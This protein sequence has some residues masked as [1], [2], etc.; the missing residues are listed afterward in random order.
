MKTPLP[1]LRTTLV[2]ST[3]AAT[4]AAGAL[5]AAH[6]FADPEE[7]TTPT[8]TRGG[9][10]AG[11]V[12]ANQPLTGTALPDGAAS[13]SKF[14]F[15][16]NGTDD[17]L[18]LAVATIAL[19]KGAEPSNGWPVVV[20]AAAPTGID[21]RCAA[22]AT[23]VKTAGDKTSEALLAKGFAVLTPDYGGI[24][25]PTA[26]Q[27]SDNAVTARHLVDA[28]EAGRV[29]AGLSPR[30]A[31]AGE[32]LGSGAAIELARK[33]TRWESG[34]LDF[35]GTAATSLPAGFADLVAGLGKSSPEVSA[36]VVADVV[37]ALASLDQEALEPVLSSKGAE[38]V[39]KAATGCADDL[40]RAVRGVSLSELVTKPL[41]GKLA[42]SVRKSLELPQRG[43]NRPV[44]L[45]QTLTDETTVVPEAL[46]YLT[47]A[48]LASNKVRASSYLTADEAD[49]KRQ[50]RDAVVA[51]IDDLL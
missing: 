27:Y 10:T 15:W 1:R 33:A 25:A 51:F 43:F 30:W 45:S 26:P 3:V 17:R 23:P 44:L 40:Q 28:V 49:G 24:G 16:T 19:P 50:E 32:G 22:S 21:A 13:G 6:A 34:A 14:S 38:L 20:R 9:Q 31:V 36:A 12:Y 18:H 37:Y 48:H 29:V 2:V 4:V 35:R 46:R 5:T 39:G 11:A 47:E 8:T 41:P 7:S 42:A